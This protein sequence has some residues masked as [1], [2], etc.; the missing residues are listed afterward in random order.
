MAT[1]VAIIFTDSKLIQICVLNLNQKATCPNGQT[2]FFHSLRGLE[3][4]RTA[5]EA[6]AEL[7]LATRPQDPFY[8]ELLWLCL[9]ALGGHKSLLIR[10]KS[11]TFKLYCNYFL[12]LSANSFKQV[13]HKQLSYCCFISFK[14]FIL[15]KNPSHQQ[16]FDSF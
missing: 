5:V 9:S 10:Y 8:V 7:C 3:R 11:N 1:N 16:P 13:G 12:S 4:I 2:A 14:V 15:R 6:F